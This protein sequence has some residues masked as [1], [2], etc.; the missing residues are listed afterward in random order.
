MY[1]A[2][3]EV[4]YDE[5]NENV[6]HD[7]KFKSDNVRLVYEVLTHYF[8]CV[9]D[10]ANTFDNACGT[11]ILWNDNSEIVVMYGYDSNTGTWS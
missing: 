11:V 1:K 7:A 4:W 3:Y 6:H 10:V 8:A 9:E 2:E 5:G